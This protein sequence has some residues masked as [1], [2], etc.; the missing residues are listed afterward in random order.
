MYCG[1]DDLN[2]VVCDV[3]CL[4]ARM[5]YAGEDDARY[6]STSSNDTNGIMTLEGAVA[7]FDS[8]E[9]SLDEGFV[10]LG[11][12]STRQHPILWS[13][14]SFQTLLDQQNTSSKS[15]REA[16]AE[17]FF[18]KYDAPAYFVSKSAVLTC[19]ANGRSTGMVVEMGHGN[20]AVVP[21]NE[22]YVVGQHA[23]RHSDVGGHG[24]DEFLHGRVLEKLECSRKAPLSPTNPMNSSLSPKQSSASVSWATIRELKESICRTSESHFDEKANA[25]IPHMPFEL[26]DGT[27]IS[28]GVERFSA[29][30]HL[31]HHN[32]PASAPSSGRGIFLP[33]IVLDAASK[34]D[35]DSKKEYLQNILV[36][37]GSS[38]FESF[39]TR[40]E[41]EI[42]AMLPS[43]KIKVLAP[44]PNER[45]L[46]AFLG[47]SIVASLGSFHEMWIS[48]TEYAEHG[49]NLVQ[50][51]CP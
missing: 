4:R 50:K 24:L 48:K 29:A 38:C 46:S 27:Q 23:V 32:D 33:E 37:G 35:A 30:E 41:R 8:L 39:P 18:E 49:A 2:A 17:L 51:K 42:A 22:G 19:F 6:I 13:E 15:D 1:G 31:F 3:G 7:S 11:V 5:G 9:T 10:R 12:E 44:P 45:K 14:N 21:V 36:G 40:L 34:G 26:P 16:I 20:T 25:N 43:A 47:G 28:L